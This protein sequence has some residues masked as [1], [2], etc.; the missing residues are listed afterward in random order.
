MFH[1]GNRHSYIFAKKAF[2]GKLLKLTYEERAVNLFCLPE[3][4]KTLEGGQSQVR[5]DCKG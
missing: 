4:I 5:P 3:M 2:S 1:Y